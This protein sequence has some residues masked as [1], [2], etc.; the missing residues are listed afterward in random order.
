[1]VN[2]MQGEIN[3][4]IPVVADEGRGVGVMYSDVNRRRRQPGAYT[5]SL[6]GST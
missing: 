6:F 3:Q 5:L 2:D 4:A 1:M